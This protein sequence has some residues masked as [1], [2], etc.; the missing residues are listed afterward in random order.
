MV[1]KYFFG[2][3]CTNQF[4]DKSQKKATKHGKDKKANGT[5]SI[6]YIILGSCPPVPQ[7][8][9]VVHRAIDDSYDLAEADALRGRF[10][11]ER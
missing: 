3:V 2:E 7:K 10:R 1:Q 8:L 9:E 5:K 6:T 4:T 11:R